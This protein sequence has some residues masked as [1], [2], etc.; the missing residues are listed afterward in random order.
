MSAS[1]T[2]GIPAA[3][4][5]TASH[6]LWN[7]QLARY[8]DTAV[9]Y[10]Y[11]AIVVVATVV[12]YYEL[13]IQYAISTAIITHYNMT[14]T[15]FV[16]VSVVGNAVG[17]FASLLAGLADRWGRANLTVYGLLITGALVAFAVPNANSKG[18]FLALIAVVSFVEGII[19]VTTPALV[20]DFSPQL[21]RASA[22]G[23]WTMGPVVGSLVVTL[24]TSH[25]YSGSTTWQDEFRYAGWAGLLVF[26]IALF[27]LRELSPQLRDQIMVSLRDRA[28]VEAKAKGLDTEA[29]L[30]GHWRQMLHTDIVGS[31]LAISLF[32][33]L[34][35]AAV[36]S[37]TVYFVTTFGYSVQ[38]TAGLLNWY[39]AANA[40][41]LVVVG[42][43]SDR[44]R[45]RKPFMLAGA[46]ASIAVLIQFALA[47]TKP[48]TSYYTFAIMVAGIG[49]FGGFTYAPWMASFTETV[50]RRNPA[51]TATGLAVYGWIIR[52]IVAASSAILPLVVSSATPL[53]D[54][55]AQV[56]AAQAQAGPALAIVQAHPQ[57]FAQLEKYPANQVP[58]ALQAQAVQEVGIPGLLT[59]QKA[60][61]QLAILGAF[62]TQVQQAAAHNP[63]DWQNWYWV[64]LGG[65]V[66][67]IPFIFLMAGRW[68]PR[69]A[70][71]DVAEHERQ[72]DE[73]MATLS[74]STTEAAA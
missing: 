5:P 51:A 37:F 10:V 8:P 55:G 1:A 70:R 62:G 69:K 63:K 12:L 23:Y 14:F 48:E 58:P 49:V 30:R 31:A 68:S 15:Y 25:T 52:I 19:L 35:F 32:L 6:S 36:G 42:F 39:W 20:R 54:H 28:I 59:V 56:A 18:M 9:R 24:V 61:P 26:V 29:A 21:G 74:S 46:I 73:Q 16:Y 2:E 34:Y 13:Y 67:F 43:L 41:S 60:A 40:I 65:E 64:C 3:P 27:G 50:E 44:V 53:V 11:L 38:R 4:R 72:I 17:A 47:A 22:M 45:V 71:E 57:L 66:V 33:L 7:R